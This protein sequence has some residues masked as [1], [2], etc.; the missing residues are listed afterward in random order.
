MK[1]FC[2]AIF[3]LSV[4]ELACVLVYAKYAILFTALNAL[5]IKAITVANLAECNYQKENLTDDGLRVRRIRKLILE[6]NFC[7][8]EIKYEKRREERR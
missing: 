3:A 5:V 6:C 7:K 2:L 4:R 1:D 8:T